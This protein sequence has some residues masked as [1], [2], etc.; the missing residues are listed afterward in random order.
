MD[1]PTKMLVATV[2][3]LYSRGARQNIQKILIKTHEADVAALIEGCGLDIGFEI[4]KLEPS[5]EKR[6]GILSRLDKELQSEFFYVLTRVEVL[7]LLSLM[8]SDDKADFLGDLTEEES[9][10]ILNSMVKKE[11]EEVAELMGYPEDSAGGI[12]NSDFLVL[13][14]N[15]TVQQSIEALQDAEDESYSTFYIY[16]INENGHLVGV[17]SLKQLLLSKKSEVLKTLMISEVISVDMKC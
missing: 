7:Q 15:Q 17:V 12:M 8:D 4:F 10:E 14:Q 16:V 1:E 2:K 9:Q 11:S 3:K 6:A 5:I 13:N